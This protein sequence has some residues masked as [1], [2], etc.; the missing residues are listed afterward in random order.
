MKA[1]DVCSAST[2]G[3]RSNRSLPATISRAA[4]ASSTCAALSTSADQRRDAGGL[5][6][7]F[8]AG[9]CSARGLGIQASHRD[10]RDD[11]RLLG[12][13]AAGSSA[14]SNAA[15][16]R[17]AS[18]SRPDQDQ[19]PHLEMQRMGGIMRI[20]MLL[21]RRACRVQRLARPAEVA[22]DEGDLRLGHHAARAGHGLLWSEDARRFAQ[23]DSRA[24][25]IA[26]L[27]HSDSAQRQRRRVVAQRHPVER[28]QRVAAGQCERR[29][30]D[31]RILVEI[32]TVLSLPPFDTPSLCLSHQ[33]TPQRRSDGS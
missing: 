9:E 23:Q 1:F 11:Q 5:G 19:A 29:R 2:S 6:R 3:K 17:S 20:A 22:R 14:G 28:P 26:E 18:S 30:I 15:S 21:Q 24:V 4:G 13:N 12:L 25:E 7:A 31:Q 27:R 8:R 33:E 32:P 16:L 10:R